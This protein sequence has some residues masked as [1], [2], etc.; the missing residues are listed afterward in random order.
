M[1]PNP[2]K[3]RNIKAMREAMLH[4]RRHK[5]QEV[6]DPLTAAEHHYIQANGGIDDRPPL[7]ANNLL[8]VGHQ[9]F[10]QRFLVL[11][12]FQYLPILTLLSAAHS[13]E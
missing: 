9:P 2:N 10:L 12:V 5:E 11:G 6:S 3:N 7:A 8:Q 4:A 13:L 1:T